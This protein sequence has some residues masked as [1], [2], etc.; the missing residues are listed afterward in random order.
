MNI[1]YL[2]ILKK[3]PKEGVIG[4]IHLHLTDIV[5]LPPM[6]CVPIYIPNNKREYLLPKPLLIDCYQISGYLPI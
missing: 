4:Y 3:I 2:E 1:L 5:K 6:G